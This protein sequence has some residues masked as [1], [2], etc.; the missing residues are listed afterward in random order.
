MGVGSSHPVPSFPLRRKI[1][2]QWGLLVGVRVLGVGGFRHLLLLA[3]V[4]QSVLGIVKGGGVTC[5]FGAVML[6]S[7]NNRR[8]PGD[9]NMSRNTTRYRPQ[10][11]QLSAP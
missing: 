7:P 2:A 4:S 1:L 9:R 5:S 3:H 11:L 10:I 6:T 8:Q